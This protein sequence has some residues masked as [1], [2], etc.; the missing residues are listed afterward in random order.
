VA[1]RV[2]HERDLPQLTSVTTDGQSR[3]NPSVA[4][5]AEVAIT[6]KAIAT[7]SNS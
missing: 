1:E 3:V 6:S 5:G 7:T 4:F 2:G